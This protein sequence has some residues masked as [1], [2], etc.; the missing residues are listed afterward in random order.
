MLYDINTMLCYAYYILYYT[1][2][3]YIEAIRYTDMMKLHELV[4]NWWMNCYA[5]IVIRKL[6]F[7]NEASNH[8]LKSTY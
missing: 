1:I 6:I 5:Y 3:Y 7:V 4:R 8:C 2:L